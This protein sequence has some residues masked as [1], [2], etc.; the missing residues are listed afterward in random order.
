M[1]LRL[2]AMSDDLAR[3]GDIFP[4]LFR[5]SQDGMSY[6]RFITKDRIVKIES[7]PNDWEKEIL[8]YEVQEIGEP[9]LWYGIDHP[10]AS[11]HDAGIYQ[12]RELLPAYAVYI[13]DGFFV[14][15][16]G[17][18]ASG[19]YSLIDERIPKRS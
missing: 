16:L 10:D 2:Q 8:F 9:I 6:I 15:A 3:A 4:V 13:D 11:Q 7:A 14:V 12:V 19:A 18:G 1:D 5:N 17:L